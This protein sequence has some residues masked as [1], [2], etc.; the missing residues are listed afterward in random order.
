MGGDEPART[1]IAAA[2][3]RRQGGRDGE[4][5]R[6]R[7]PRPGARGDRPADRR[8][9]PLRGGGRRRDPGP[10]PARDGPRREPG[11][12]AVRGIVNG[13]TNYILSAM[14]D[15]GRDYDD[16][17][18]R[19]P[20]R[21]LRRGRPDRRR[22]GPRRG[23]QARDPRPA[24]VRRPGSTRP[25]STTTRRRRPGRRA[26][27]GSPASTPT[28]SPARGRRGPGDQAARRGGR[29][30]TRADGD[31]R[32]VGP[33]DARSRRTRPSAG[34]P[35]CSTGSRSRPS[36][37]GRWRS[38]GPA[39]ADRPT[40]SAV[41]GDLIAIARGLGSTW[42]GLAGRD[43]RA[44]R[45]ARDDARSRRSAG[46]PAD[47]R[48]ALPRAS[49]PSPTPRP[50][51]SLGEGATPLVPLRRLG[52]AAR[53]RRTSTPRS[54]ARTRP[55]RSRTAGMVVAVA[56]AVEDGARAIICASTGN[57]S[58]S[59]AAY[60]AA[61]RARGR[62]R[63]AGRQDRD[64]QAAPGARR[65][66]PGRR[67]RR[68]LR[69]RA[70]GRP[71]AGRAGRPSGHARELGQP[72]PARGPEDRRRS[73]SATTSGGAPDVL[74]I[75]VGNA[76]NISAYWAGFREYARRRASS[77]RRRGCS[78]SRPPAP[79]RSS[80]AGRSTSRRRSRPRS[81]SA[82]R[83]RGRRRS[84]PATR[85]AAAIEA[86]T[87]DEILAAY[88]TLAAAE[89]IFCEPSSAA[90]VAGVHR[91]R[92]ATA[93]STR[94]ATVVCVL[95]GT[96]LKDP[97]DRGADRGRAPVIEAEPTRR[98]ARRGG[99]RMVTNWLAELD[100]RRVDR[101]G[102]GDERQPRRRLRLPRRGARADRTGSRSRSAA[103]AA[104]RSS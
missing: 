12:R 100:G 51:L 82:T 4:Q 85:A 15:E 28:T 93:R 75:P 7:P 53:P 71:R 24:R 83:R 39:P 30:T 67:G 57:T 2:L 80:S 59:A 18:R 1:L 76:G 61:A 3:A 56:K 32:G 20:G 81:G 97:D 90:G 58:A 77:T 45:P 49:C 87:D 78:A 84:P 36:R 69:R 25:T 43:G 102:A 21:G 94:D 88:A 91:A 33:A 74:A 22:R 68:Q 96:G 46:R 95:T 64:G 89:G 17:P 6:H 27:A 70:P 86:V 41:L 34:R 40:A 16:G 44:S 79:R 52:R 13:T 35:A 10:R 47:P 103:G 54:R 66:R 92:R 55:A 65:R 62:R 11:R 8:G 73:R 26:A 48:R 23:E 5:A 31:D 101:R 19:R 72:A 42:A 38:A 98:R 9:P 60:G 63:P 99:A 37:S 29:P 14:T 50:S 104:A